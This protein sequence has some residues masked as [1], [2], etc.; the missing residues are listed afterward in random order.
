MFS[1]LKA[2]VISLIE[3]ETNIFKRLKF[4]DVSQ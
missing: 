2:K 1:V 3:Y 4:L